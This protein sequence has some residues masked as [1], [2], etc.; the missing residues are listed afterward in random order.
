MKIALF[1]TIILATLSVSAKEF[2]LIDKKGLLKS[3]NK[4]LELNNIEDAFKKGDQAQI[5]SVDNKMI[6]MKVLKAN[7]KKL[8][9]KGAKKYSVTAKEFKELNNS[10]MEVILNDSNVKVTVNGTVYENTY[11]VQTIKQVV[12]TLDNG[13]VLNAYQIYLTTPDTQYSYM[14]MEP[15][16]RMN[17]TISTETPGIAQLLKMTVNGMNLFD[18]RSYTIQ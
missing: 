17:I 2:R 10:M 4:E 14:G 15:M 13:E 1:L 8:V 16:L 9:L 18:L 7:D 3:I 6:T 11:I 5:L 12:H